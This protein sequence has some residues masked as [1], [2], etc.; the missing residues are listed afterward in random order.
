MRNKLNS[1]ATIIIYLL[2][3]AYCSAQ[4]VDDYTQIREQ[5]AN[6]NA[7]LLERK[8]YFTIYIENNTLKGNS[9][10]S[11]RILINKEEGL[12]Y[13]SR[14]IG[15]SA[16][17]EAKN[18]KA[19]TQVPNSNNKFTK[20]DVQNIELKSGTEGS[21]FY[22]DSKDYSFTYPAVQPGS[23]LNLQY[24]YDYKEPHFIGSHYW[25]TYIPT[26][27]NELVI[28][29][30][31]RININFKEYNTEGFGLEFTKEE[32]KNEIIYTWKASNKT[33]KIHY[34]N[35]P[36]YKY[37]EPHIQ[38]YI[39]DYE[40]NGVKNTLLKT[41][42]DLYNWYILLQKNLNQTENIKLKNLAD[43]LTLNCKTEDEK[44]EKIFYWV[45][46]NIA[47]VAFEDG[48]GGFIPRDASTVCNRK[49]GDC[50]D[51]ASIIKEMLRIVGVKAYLGWLGSRDIPYTYV[52]LPTPA[53][54]N[55]MI[56]GYKNNKGNWVFLDGTGK[57]A[58]INLT[59]SFIQGKQVMYGIT[60]D[61]FEIVTVPVS[62]TAISITN[63]SIAITINND[64]I[65]G[66]GKATLTGYDGLNYMYR[67]NAKNKKDATEYFKNYFA[68]GNNKINYAEVNISLNERVPVSINYT[69]DL[70][71][72]AKKNEND[73]YLNLN[74][75]KD[76]PPAKTNK[77]RVVPLSFDYKNTV[78]ATTTLTIPKGYTASYIPNNKQL[79]HPF[80][81]FT[82]TYAQKG[83][84]IIYTTS[85]YVNVLLVQVNELETLN[86]IIHEYNKS[87]NQSLTLTKIK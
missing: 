48:F 41:P 80:A 54:D 13:Q 53:V 82:N 43:S 4:K 44:V 70:T 12:K 87:I 61:T 72:Y 68:K 74:L 69:F 76:I 42:Q 51:M 39:T 24:S 73:I 77:D 38:F 49:Y 7:I 6:D 31:K 64:T 52:E 84:K 32:T 79:I 59:T 46:D 10:V 8:E 75:N 86:S 33:P 30:D 65:K 28:K 3:I 29:V 55:H 27:Y 11:E 63:D 50:K 17:V 16:F 56:A 23:I 1:F 60:N 5:M 78:K 71:D 19:F 26:L 40:I 83:N 21:V 34:N 85:F 9:A 67:T 18:I 58:P 37:Y 62:D 22:D 15:T 57:K 14:E 35:A 36:N 66:T 45:Q 81:G 25:T 2:G 47:Y 20:I